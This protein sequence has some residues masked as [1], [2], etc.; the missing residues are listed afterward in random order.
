MAKPDPST[1]SLGS[2]KG[3]QRAA[4]IQSRID[5]LSG[6]NVGG[7]E[8]NALRSALVWALARLGHLESRKP[9]ISQAQAV[10]IIRAWQDAGMRTTLDGDE[11]V[12]DALDLEQLGIR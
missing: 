10:A 4:R 7:W 8:A 5:Y 12:L 11:P 3:Q 6:P 2:P 9:R 1:V